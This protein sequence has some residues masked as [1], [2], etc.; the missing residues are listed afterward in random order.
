MRA[1]HTIETPSN[2]VGA[3]S[4]LR[5]VGEDLTE[6]FQTL[7]MKPITVGQI[8]LAPVVGLDDALVA[9]FDQGSL[10]IMP[11]G[12]IGIT[13]AISK[14]LDS[15]GIQYENPENPLVRY[16]EAEDIHEARLLA[17]LSV[18]PSP[19]AVDVLLDQPSRWR[20]ATDSD[21]LAD[22]SV[23]N[24]LIVPPVVVAVGRANIGKSS[25]VNALAGV[26]VAMVSDQ[27]G[28]TR[29]H[30]GVM[31]DLAGLAVRWVDTPGIDERVEVGEELDLVEPVIRAADLIVFAIDHDDPAGELDPR[32][33]R[34]LNSSTQL[35]R[36]GVR[37]DL[38]L[39]G[40]DVDIRCS[41]RS[42]EGVEGL[43]WA[44]NQ[45]LIPPETLT[46]PHRW[47]YWDS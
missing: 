12:G 33:Q 18:A 11:H 16:P 23:L 31:L 21:P 39:C 1:T 28:T 4:I 30:V 42:G 6:V 7:Q 41:S 2:T 24:R 46:G 45:A 40:A 13:R 19:M 44:L 25:L 8:R 15:L 37:S 9:R 22:A 47:R 3:V 34:L 14:K 5:I 20:S 29:D 26:S 36:V 10:F 38:G 27:A 32:L 17:V 43:A 35:L